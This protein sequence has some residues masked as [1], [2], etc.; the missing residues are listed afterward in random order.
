[1]AQH[2]GTIE[3]RSTPGQGSTFSVFLPALAQAQVP[4]VVDDEFEEITS[5]LGDAPLSEVLARA[6]HMPTRPAS[7]A[8]L[9]SSRPASE[10]ERPRGARPPTDA[11]P[12]SSGPASGTPAAGVVG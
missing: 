1:V 4:P 3:V 6:A 7:D 8:G 5:D 11:D 2:G 9:A 10:A 12:G